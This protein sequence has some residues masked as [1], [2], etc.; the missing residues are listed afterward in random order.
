[1]PC[2]GREPANWRGLLDIEL[3][4]WAVAIE[5][6]LD[7][8]IEVVPHLVRDAVLATESLRDR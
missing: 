8:A 6:V 3:S 7:Q 5:H 2:P 4:G 1:V